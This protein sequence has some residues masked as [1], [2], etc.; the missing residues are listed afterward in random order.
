MK[1]WSRSF[2]FQKLDEA[3][4]KANVKLIKKMLKNKGS[5]RDINDLMLNLFMTSQ[6]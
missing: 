4:V 6:V 3:Q 5:E 2:Q 1:V